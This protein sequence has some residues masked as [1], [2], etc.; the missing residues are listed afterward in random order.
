MD[1][2]VGKDAVFSP[3]T[4]RVAPPGDAGSSLLDATRETGERS[5]IGAPPIGPARGLLLG[6]AI[7][8]VL[9]VGIIALGWR[10]LHR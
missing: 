7:G 10:L 1:F 2:Q 6:L 8:A 4:T 9:W 3:G 5:G